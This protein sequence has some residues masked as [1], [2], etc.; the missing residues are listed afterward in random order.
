MAV[1]AETTKSAVSVR[2]DGGFLGF[3][4]E[5]LALV[6]VGQALAALKN[7]DEWALSYLVFYLGHCMQ[8]YACL[9]AI[10]TRNVSG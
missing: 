3:C 9:N 1:R 7:A 10:I 5:G 6:S 2:R 4:G 8:G